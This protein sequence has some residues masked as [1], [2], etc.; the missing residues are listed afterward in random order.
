MNFLHY[1]QFS[2]NGFLLFLNIFLTGH[3]IYCKA[4]IWQST[5]ITQL[6]LRTLVFRKVMNYSKHSLVIRTVK[7]KHRENCKTLPF[8]NRIGCQCVKLFLFK[9]VNI[10]TITIVTI[11]TVTIT[12]INIT[13]VIIITVIFTT[14]AMTTVAMTTVAITTVTITTVTIT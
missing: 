10:T 11:T 9:D 3:E 13:T 7:I 8:E 2:Q 4:A 12:T 6:F 5:L 1:P 14:G